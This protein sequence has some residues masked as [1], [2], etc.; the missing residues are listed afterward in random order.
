MFSEDL[1]T[2]QTALLCSG[3]GNV[4]CTLNIYHLSSNSVNYTMYVTNMG[5]ITI[6]HQFFS[7]SLAFF[8]YAVHSFASQVMKQVSSIMSYCVVCTTISTFEPE[9]QYNCDSKSKDQP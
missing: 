9:W 5:T 3:E 4:R 6:S 8:L 7:Y 2:K 1:G